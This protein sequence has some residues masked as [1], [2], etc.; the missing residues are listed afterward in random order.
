M[1]ACFSIRD[2]TAAAGKAG[3]ERKESVRA[4]GAELERGDGAALAASLEAKLAAMAIV[5]P[6]DGVEP[7]T[8]RR[9]AVNEGGSPFRWSLLLLL[10]TAEAES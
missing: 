2:R 6:E 5:E 10:E 9:S 7:A 3:A 4:A 1:G 8:P